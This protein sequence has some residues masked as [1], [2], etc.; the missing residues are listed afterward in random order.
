MLIA[1]DVPMG[2]VVRF[3]IAASCSLSFSDLG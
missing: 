1:A 2:G 3:F